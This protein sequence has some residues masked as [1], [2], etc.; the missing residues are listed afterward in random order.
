MFR[1]FTQ[2]VGTIG[3]RLRGVI[4]PI[5]TY[6][7]LAKRNNDETGKPG[8]FLSYTTENDNNER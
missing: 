6:V 2:V 1:R 8:I 5:F 3:Y 7:R 4:M